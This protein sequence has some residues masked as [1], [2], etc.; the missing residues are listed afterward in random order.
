MALNKL[1]L[2]NDACRIA[3]VERL[4]SLDEEREARY[5]LDQIYDLGAVEY[6][7]RIALPAFARK[8]VGLQNTGFNSGL[9]YSGSFDVPSDYVSYLP[10]RDGLQSLYS[11]TALSQPIEDHIRDNLRIYA[12]YDTVY[13]R[14]IFLNETYGTW[15]ADFV[16]LFTAYLGKELCH[17]IAPHRLAEANR[18][19]QELE[20]KARSFAIL[21][22]PLGGRTKRSNVQLTEDWLPIYNDA[23]QILGEEHILN[24]RDTSALK[25]M[26]DQS[27]NAR[28]VEAMLEVTNWNFP[29]SSAKLEENTRLEPEWGFQYVHEKPTDLHRLDG[30][31][32]DELMQIPLKHYQDEG[33]NIYSNS[34]PVYIKYVSSSYVH[35]VAIWPDYFRRLVAGRMAFDVRNDK[36]LDLPPQRRM[37]ISAEY[38]ER[39]DTA[40][41]VDAMQSPP[42]VISR[43][44]WVNSRYFGGNRNRPD[45]GYY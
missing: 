31:F 8:T 11:D 24:I 28:A 38:D 34:T 20:E 2:Y 17:R 10:E 18:S 13:M 6:C 45:D 40:K 23:A 41:N 29:T 26:L 37:E 35:N 14:Y 30:F 39:L 44:S 3:G 7:L 21:Q 33:L 42:I 27:R 32:I 43:G 5:K 9:D 22:E 4:A 12:N 25:T 19:F 15:D 1:G 16:R 36:R